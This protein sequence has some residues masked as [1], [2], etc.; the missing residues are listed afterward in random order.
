M[1][2]AKL[3]REQNEEQIAI[4][5]KETSK[6]LFELRCKAVTEKVNPNQKRELRRQIARIKTIQSERRIK[7][8]S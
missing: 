3:L 2:S 6:E 4:S 8:Q 1:D 5:L 7:S